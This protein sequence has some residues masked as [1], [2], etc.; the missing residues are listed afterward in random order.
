ML[1]EAEL[2]VGERACY[3]RIFVRKIQGMSTLSIVQYILHV[4]G[5]RVHAQKIS[6]RVAWVRMV[7]KTDGT[8]FRLLIRAVLAQRRGTLCDELLI[9]LRPYH[10]DDDYLAVAI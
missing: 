1:R 9:A 3:T 8:L 7:R 2:L 5:M 4:N 6:S 10:M